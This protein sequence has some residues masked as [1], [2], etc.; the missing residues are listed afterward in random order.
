M[1]RFV[2]PFFCAIAIVTTGA[3]CS[4]AD[5]IDDLVNAQLARQRTPGA[6]VAVVKAGR[7][8]KVAA[9]GV[10]A[11]AGGSPVRTDTVFP[12]QSMTKQFT[13]AGVLLLVEAGKID[14]DAPVSRYV[15]N[16]PPTWEKMTV[17]HLLTQ[18]SGL[19]DFINEPARNLRRD[20]TDEQLLQGE[21]A[22]PLKFAPGDAWDYSNTNYLLLGHIIHRVSGRWYGDFLAEH[23]F[24]PLGMTRTGVVSA[25]RPDLA[26][27]AI[28]H[29]SEN[30]RLRPSTILPA[31]IAGYAGGGIRSTVLDLAKWDAALHRGQILS[32]A[33]LALMWTP[34]KLNN[35]TTHGYGFGW[36]IDSIANH[37]RVWHAGTW[38]GF[39]AQIERYLDDELTVIVLTNLTTAAPARIARAIAGSYVPALAAPV[40]RPIADREPAVTARFFEVLRRSHDGGLRAEE[41]TADVWSYVATHLDQMRRD[42]AAIGPIQKLTLVARTE[43]AG[44]RSYRYQA[45]FQRTTL[46]FHFE[47]TPDDKIATMMPEQIN[48]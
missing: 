28:G 36:E 46:L 29:E 10:T 12:I 15:E 33:S 37:R 45:R 38:L 18:T 21:A 17:R 13:A 16:S 7:I 26:E 14:L 22:R 39:A 35:G 20:T 24:Q 31:S 2:F 41:F 40:Y 48:Q 32:R 25:R 11:L 34:V 3:S 5:E 44:R 9:Y 8:V 6:A 43:S 4:R 42:M 47:L 19:H 30:G 27:Q 23:I 1:T